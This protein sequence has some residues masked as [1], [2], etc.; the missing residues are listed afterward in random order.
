M[1]TLKKRLAIL[2]MISMVVSVLSTNVQVEGKS[3]IKLSKKKL[4]LYVGRTKT[5]KLKG[6]K[7]TPKWSSSK[8][9]VA[10]VSKK[11]KIKAKKK[12]TTVITAK[13]KKKNYKCKVTVKKHTAPKPQTSPEPSQTKKP[14]TPPT[15]KATVADNY[16]KLADYIVKNGTYDSENEEYYIA[17]LATGTDKSLFAEIQYNLDGTFD[18]TVMYS[19][20]AADDLVMLTITPP[21]FT[22]GAVANIFVYSE[23]DLLYANGEVTLSSLTKTNQSITYT[24]T[25]VEDEETKDKLCELG[26]IVLGLGLQGWSAILKG[27]NLGLS[28]KDLGFTSYEG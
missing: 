1:K 9:S 19:T 27:T 20:D 21:E 4:T 23:D 16:K 13:L 15:Q 2:L 12:G 28:L 14:T 22:K 18:F 25:N 8:K 3:K 7:K 10:T 24:S 6:T 11:G 5:L 26:E 17:D